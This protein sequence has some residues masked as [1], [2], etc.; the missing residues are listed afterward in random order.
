MLKKDRFD[1]LQNVKIISCPNPLL[2][3]FKIEYFP[4]N[5]RSFKECQ[6]ETLKV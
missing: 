1:R 3:G 2:R 4:K 5:F 6:P